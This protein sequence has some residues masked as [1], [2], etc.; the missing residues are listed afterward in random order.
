MALKGKPIRSGREAL[1]VAGIRLFA[2]RGYTGAS[3]REICKAAGITRPVLYYHFGS[4]DELYRQLIADC[5]EQHQRS[6]RHLSQMHGAVRDKLVRILYSEIKNSRQNP[7]R[8]RMIL[9]IIIAPSNE[10]F[11]LISVKMEELHAIIA[12]VFQKGI[13][14]G[15]L[16]G[17]PNRLATA[18][19]GFSTIT[20]MQDVF[21]KR[22]PFTRQN[23]EDFI[24]L[25]LQG[26]KAIFLI[27]KIH[28]R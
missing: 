13:D 24:D 9:R 1:V 10:H 23:S 8:T 15:E 25:L 16:H 5:M 26:S 11:H 22:K 28:T 14:S 21:T 4:K 19:M 7:D 27:P 3:T 20:I 18:L 12:S 17:D 2:N 6:I